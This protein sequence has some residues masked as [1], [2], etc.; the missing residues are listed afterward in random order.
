MC[1]VV[2]DLS[3][4][5]AANANNYLITA[6]YN[7][8]YFGQLLPETADHCVLPYAAEEVPSELRNV[9]ISVRVEQAKSTTLGEQRF[10]PARECVVTRILASASNGAE[11]CRQLEQIVVARLPQGS[12]ITANDI[13][14][15][16]NMMA[17]LELA[18]RRDSSTE[19]DETLAGP[20]I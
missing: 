9:R 7:K 19:I 2:P 5:A 3:A 16:G 10:V 20:S 8:I 6:F 4:V 12:V 13:G 1:L 14:A 15:V 18:G 17:L 11:H